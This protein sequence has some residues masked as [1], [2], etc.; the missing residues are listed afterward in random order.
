MIE[1]EGAAKQK[2]QIAPASNCLKTEIQA[3]FVNCAH[4]R[5]NHIRISYNL[6]L[7]GE[8]P[9]T[10]AMIGVSDAVLIGVATI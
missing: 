10:S 5:N 7:E 3:D 6:P 2:I 4:H 9:Q 8:G 1:A